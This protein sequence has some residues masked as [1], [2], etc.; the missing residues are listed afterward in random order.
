MTIGLKRVGQIAITVTDLKRA[1]EFYRDRLG[2][3][4][5]F[6][7][8]NMAF[9]SLGEVRLMVGTPEGSGKAGQTILYYLVDDIQAAHRALTEEGVTFVEPPQLVAKMPDHD[10]WIGFA[11]DQDG[12]AFGLM[13]EVRTGGTAGVD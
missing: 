11:R 4:L 5:L 9:F 10:L 2:M 12:N 3:K 8:P 1:V 6:E 7:V 13:S